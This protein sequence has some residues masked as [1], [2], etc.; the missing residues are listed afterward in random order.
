[1]PLSH[2]F[3]KKLPQRIEFAKGLLVSLL[4]LI[5]MI[6]D[7]FSERIDIIE[8]IPSMIGVP[9]AGVVAYMLVWKLASLSNTLTVKNESPGIERVSSSVTV[10]VEP[11]KPER[12]IFL[13]L[14]CFIAIV[15][16][17]RLLWPEHK[18]K[19]SHART[20]SDE[21]IDFT[22]V[23]LNDVYEISPLDSGRSGGLARVAT[24]IEQLKKNNKNVYTMLA[25][26]FLFPSALGTIRDGPANKEIKGMQM[27]EVLNSVPVDLVT[28][29]NHE[30]DIDSIQYLN[31]RID[32][33][34]FDWI[35]AN[36]VQKVN[37]QPFTK[38]YGSDRKPIP[39][40]KI[41]EFSNAS[42]RVVRL[43]ILGVTIG[44]TETY[45]VD[46]TDEVEAIRNS[47]R[48]LKNSGANVIIALTHLERDRDTALAKQ[49]PEI[50]LFVGGHEHINS[51]DTIYHA[52]GE[53]TF[54]AKADANARTVYIHQLRYH[55]GTNKVSIQSTLQPINEQLSKHP[56]VADKV[57]YWNNW[58]HEKWLQQNYAPCKILAQLNEPLDGT[59]KNIRT[60]QTNLTRLIAKAIYDACGDAR[61]DASIY[62]SGS[63]RLDDTIKTVVTE[64]DVI[65]TIPYGGKI[66]IVTTK[67]HLLNKLLNASRGCL[68]KGCFLQYYNIEDRGGS[69]IINGKEIQNDS[70][71][72][73]AI[74]DYL[75]KGRQD[76]MTFFHPKADGIVSVDSNVSNMYRAKL[77]KAV[78]KY[79]EDNYP[80]PSMINSADVRVPCY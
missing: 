47:I 15:F 78:S 79:I 5:A 37:R 54:V 18:Q 2:D 52:S 24:L 26:D 77:I 67:G 33:S 41:V 70:S 11:L 76:N 42:G 27:V 53:K 13:W 31:E 29:G 22:L 49:F 23:Q 1:M 50:Q 73:L 12:L 60:T 32:K 75:A 71:Y 25:G 30:F 17:I 46:Y 74:T 7:F 43:G 3:E 66:Y 38:L 61:L 10:P 63:I 80:K 65:R 62:N 45:Y 6:I 55:A 36:V 19:D 39:P 69:W 44:T 56:R 16:A 64:Y 51:L 4:P 57:D 20:S 68:K 35:S 21:V 8:Y 34:N 9:A 72:R 48:L 59:E 28:F 58:A 40:V 14:I